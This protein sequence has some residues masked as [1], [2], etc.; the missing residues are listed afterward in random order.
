MVVGLVLFMMFIF[1]L[2]CLFI[3]M[4]SLPSTPM[5]RMIRNLVTISAL[6]IYV[7][8]YAEGHEQIV[9]VRN[10]YTFD[11]YNNTEFYVCD[12]FANL[13]LKYGFK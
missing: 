8:L 10:N 9:D 12:Y 3:W 6:M 11:Y 13:H 1:T 7:Y 5:F 4:V 2:T